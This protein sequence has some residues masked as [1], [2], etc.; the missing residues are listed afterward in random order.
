MISIYKAGE[1][2]A[3]SHQTII[4]WFNQ[5]LLIGKRYSFNKIAIQ[6]KSLMKLIKP[7]KEYEEIR[8]NLINLQNKVIKET[9]QVEKICNINQSILKHFNMSIQEFNLMK[10]ILYSNMNIYVDNITER[11]SDIIYK[12]MAGYNF[13][14]I[15][16]ELGV[17][18]ARIH[19]LFQRALKRIRVT[20]LRLTSDKY[21]DLIKENKLLKE[22]VLIY[23][24]NAHF[25]EFKKLADSVFSYEDKP[26]MEYKL[27]VRTLNCLKAADIE[28]LSDFF[29]Y[30]RTDGF[31]TFLKF[32]NFGRNSYNELKEFLRTEF[33]LDTELQQI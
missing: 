33:N 7:I 3:V 19:Q 26:L 21:Y 2:A 25:S 8:D 18:H 14:Q 30:I 9:K 6:E 29:N 5:G 17:T 16:T 15:A 11:D 31:Y 4:N 28:K 10:T 13:E 27:S 12:V 23:E 20:K 22:K 32:R 24:S 1:L